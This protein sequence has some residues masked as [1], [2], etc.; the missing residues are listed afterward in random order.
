MIPEGSSLASACEIGTVGLV[1]E[2]GLG[3]G[4]MGSSFSTNRSEH[5]SLS[6]GVSFGVGDLGG[7]GW[8]SVSRRTVGMLLRTGI[9]TESSMRFLFLRGSGRPGGVWRF[10]CHGGFILEVQDSCG[11]AFK[12]VAG[13]FSRV[14][15]AVLGVYGG[16]QGSQLALYLW[17]AALPERS[18]VNCVALIMRHTVAVISLFAL[19]LGAR[20]L[21][22]HGVRCLTRG[23]IT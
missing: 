5:P 12:Q 8:L 23:S 15:S 1:G 18:F 19:I 20:A 22:V 13:T 17:C 2:A 7:T 3:G 4:P 6:A 16:R 11:R 9:S 10:F 21:V 14:S